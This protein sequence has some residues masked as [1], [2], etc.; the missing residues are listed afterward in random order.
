MVLPVNPLLRF[1]YVLFDLGG[2]LIYFE[3]DF[4]PA[5]ATGINEALRHLR[6]LGYEL[7]PEVFPA[8][9]R[10]LIN[11]YYQK[12]S[13]Q[14][15]EF[16]SSHVLKEALRAHGYSD[17]REE[18][19]TAAL[20]EMYAVLQTRWLPE[21]DAVPTLEAL[22]QRGYRLGLVSNASDDADVQI[23]VDNAGLRPYFDFI[24]TSANAG[25]RKPSPNIFNQALA[26]WGARPAD[27]AMV[28]DTVSA[29]ISGAKN[30]GILSIWISRRAETE[31]NRTALVESP[32]DATILTL[33]ELPG[34]LENW[35]A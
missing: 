29:D 33:S 11:E 5:L 13:D 30:L 21:D 26:F 19:L 16:T 22:L 25:Y 12:R 3:G 20:K 15:V 34:L 23:L 1:P 9:Y 32:P 4:P 28:G 18:H 2:T 8:A 17:P 6:A 7:D 27:A 14:L 31:E 35:P 24:L 10:T